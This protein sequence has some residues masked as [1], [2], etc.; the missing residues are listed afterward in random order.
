MLAEWKAYK[1]ICDDLS[2]F[3]GLGIVVS[4][5]MRGDERHKPMHYLQMPNIRDSG[6]RNMDDSQ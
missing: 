6:T 3:L 5:G 1:G 4:D 2:P